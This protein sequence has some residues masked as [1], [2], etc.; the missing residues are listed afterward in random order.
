MSTTMKKEPSPFIDLLIE[1]VAPLN[2]KE[3][4]MLRKLSEQKSTP[5]SLLGDQIIPTEGTIRRLTLN[6][7][8]KE[9]HTIAKSQQEEPSSVETHLE[10]SAPYKEQ[11]HERTIPDT[12]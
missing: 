10:K 5:S 2:I 9:E 11:E 1:A 4:Y 7:N 3:P 6:E 8:P 12:S